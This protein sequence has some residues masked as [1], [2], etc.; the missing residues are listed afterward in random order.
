MELRDLN[1]FIKA[2]ETGH[3]GRAASALGIT[4]PALTQ[5]IA[6]LERKLN[7]PLFERRAK[8]I[9]LTSFGEHVLKTARRLRNTM[10]DAERELADLSTG[11]S[12]HLRIGM[13]LA[14]A[15]H[16]LPAAC[17]RLLKRL[18]S[19]KLAITAGTGKSLIPQLREGLLDAVI[20]GLPPETESDIAQDVIMQDH[21][22]VL[23]RKLH[24]YHRRRVNAKDLALA[25]WA[26]PSSGTLSTVWLA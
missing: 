5:C 2:A 15:Q 12:G 7:A 13:G 6:R 25:R 20:S 3:V 22:I 19:L 9:R 21:V 10:D 8:G 26:L 11:T 17:T 24:P 1:Y 18:P 4:Q 23:A 16:L 14:M